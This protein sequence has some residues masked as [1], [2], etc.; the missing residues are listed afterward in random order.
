MGTN[1]LI[2]DNAAMPLQSFVTI[3]G[4]SYSALT[5]TRDPGIAD[6]MPMVEWSNDLLNWSAAATTEV[7]RVLSSGL[8]T[9]TVRSNVP[10]GV[11]Q[12]ILRVKVDA[13]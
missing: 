12:Q 2:P 6:L 7:S 3:S 5:F 11:G 13:P 10:V 9:I 1:P 4:L 8:E